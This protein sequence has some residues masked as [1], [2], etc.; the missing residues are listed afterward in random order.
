[1]SSEYKIPFD[2]VIKKSKEKE[3]INVKNARIIRDFKYRCERNHIQILSPLKYIDLSEPLPKNLK[4]VLK[5]PNGKEYEDSI[6]GC[7]SC[8]CL[9]KKCEEFGLNQMT[10]EFKKVYIKSKIKKRY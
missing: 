10:T 3:K 4:I 9:C 1:M 8:L 5:C 7:N 2:H 6:M